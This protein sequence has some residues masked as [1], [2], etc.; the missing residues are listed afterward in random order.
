MQDITR[1]D[2]VRNS[3][4]A[5]AAATAVVAPAAAQ[6][7]ASSDGAIKIL[8]I[9]C[10]PRKGKSTA[11]ALGVCL[12]AAREV[13][14]RIETELIELAGLRIN[15]SVAAGIPL[16]EG[17]PDD[18]PRLVPLLADPKVRGI[19][20]GTPVY[21][22]NMSSLCRAFLERCMVLYQNKLALSNKV[23]GVVAVG[24]TRNGGQ[25]VTIQSVQISLFCQEMIIV[26]NG[27]PHARLGGT[28][29]SG[30]EGGVL[31]D[32]FGLTTT[33]ALGRRV[34]EVALRVA[35]LS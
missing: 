1:R 28:V 2:F 21:F 4:A 7:T 33:K 29:W 31:K 22:G 20:L 24:G 16:A 6:A 32:E 13:S 12:Q 15:G 8:A 30:A 25:E 14:P 9:S 3:V 23:A 34:A 26:G 18:F 5:S 10:S 27:R 11:A 35:G 19:I 17:E